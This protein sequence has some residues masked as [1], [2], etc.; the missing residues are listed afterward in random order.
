[1]IP[2]PPAAAPAPARVTEDEW[3]GCFDLALWVQGLG[4]SIPPHV[5]RQ[6]KSKNHDENKFNKSLQKFTS[7]ALRCFLQEFHASDY[8]TSLKKVH[9]RRQVGASVWALTETFLPVSSKF[10]VLWEVYF[11][12]WGPGVDFY[13]G[14]N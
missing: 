7:F 2:A 8:Y 10:F 3:E 14:M 11:F 1:M 12:L 9:P 13:L 5:W 4:L 6:A